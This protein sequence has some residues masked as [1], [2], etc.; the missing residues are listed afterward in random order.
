M[1]KDD[2][3]K[4]KF[5]GVRGSY[6]MSDRD[7]IEFGGNTPCVSVII[8]DKLLIFDAG[9]GIIKLGNELNQTDISAD[10]FITHMHHDHIEGLAFFE[11]LFE[12]SNEFNI[13][14]P[15][16][17]NISLEKELKHFINK[18]VY[19]FSFRY[20]KSKHTFFNIKPNKKIFLNSD[21]VIDTIK[22]NHPGSCISYKVN[23][24]D[25]K[26]CYL[27]DNELT[28]DN[29]NK[30]IDFVRG[31]DLLIIDSTYID[32]KSPKKVGWGHSTWRE[33]LDIAI[34]GNVKKIVLYH[35]DSK[36][37]DEVLLNVE[38][39]AKKIYNDVVC[40]REGMEIAI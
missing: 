8:N 15:V 3:I 40:A 6:P 35:H 28:D 9:T 11:Q 2:I 18:P 19:P 33:S 36:S 4:I 29:K 34:E 23:Y 21:I 39:E 30:Y 27:T 20:M 22:N 1:L 38:N 10:I 37:S 13:Y 32:N 31:V 5:Y 14:A 7:F 26:I 12:E 16:C 24:Q 25:K 17:K